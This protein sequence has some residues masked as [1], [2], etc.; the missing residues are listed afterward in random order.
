M[1]GGCANGHT[2]AHRV[3]ES[4]SDSYQVNNAETASFKSGSV[5]RQNLCEVRIPEHGERTV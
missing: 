5:S 1:A 4:E 2:Y 3:R